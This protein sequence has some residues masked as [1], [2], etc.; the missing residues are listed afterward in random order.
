VSLQT[1]RPR[2]ATDGLAIRTVAYLFFHSFL[3]LKENA[4]KWGK[5]CI[6]G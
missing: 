2:T 1:A 5:F 6:F 4:Q 3:E